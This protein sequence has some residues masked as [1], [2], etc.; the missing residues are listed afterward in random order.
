MQEAFVVVVAGRIPAQLARGCLD[1]GCR[2]VCASCSHGKV[3]VGV[4][5]CLVVVVLAASSLHLK[6]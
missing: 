5:F 4:V 2:A 6:T 1:V 3:F